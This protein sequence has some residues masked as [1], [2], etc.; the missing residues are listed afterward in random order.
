MQCAFLARAIYLSCLW[1][2]FSRAALEALNGLPGV[3]CCRA[4]EEAAA[5]APQ[6]MSMTQSSSY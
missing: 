4:T 2:A 6:L 3:E 1:R 5:A